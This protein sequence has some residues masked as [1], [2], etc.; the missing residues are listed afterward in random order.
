MK[1]III[2]VAVVIGM[3]VILQTRD[4]MEYIAE[5]VD[6]LEVEVTP[7]EEE[8]RRLEWEKEAEEV[9]QQHIRVRELEHQAEVLRGQ[10]KEL[11]EQIKAIELELGT[12]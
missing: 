1:A 10:R 7:S 5:P 2:A 6:V 12:Y 9:R 8:L 3:V 4:T 11:D